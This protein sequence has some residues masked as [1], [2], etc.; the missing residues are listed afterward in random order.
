[1]R[2]L[3]LTG[4]DPRMA[5]IGELT[6]PLMEA[7]AVR[8]GFDFRCLRIPAGEFPYP[9]TAATRDALDDYDRVLWL[10]A[11]Q[12]ITN[13]AVLPPDGGGFHASLD[14]GRDATEPGHFSLCG[15][16]ADRSV[17]GM[18]AAA[19]DMREQW[20]SEPFPE[21]GPMRRLY[22]EGWAAMT[23]IHPRRVFNAVPIEVHPTV[24][25]PWQPGDWQC[26]LTMIDVPA[27]VTLFHKIR[28]QACK[29]LT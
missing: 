19:A 20:R 6:T 8:H 13:P 5:P 24:Q 12:I 28:E 21:Q 1:M 3:L 26:H 27:R 18:F 7:Y 9:H 4:Y 15:Y 23:T 2:T 11:D 25:E 29:F 10:D 17:R 22:A 14:W 16:A